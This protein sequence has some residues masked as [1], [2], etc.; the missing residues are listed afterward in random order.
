MFVVL[1]WQ[2]LLFSRW[3]SNVFLNHDTIN[4]D[5]ERHRREIKMVHCTYNC[6]FSM[7]LRALETVAEVA[8]NASSTSGGSGSSSRSRSEN[9]TSSSSSN[10]DNPGNIGTWFETYIYIYIS[11]IMPA[12]YLIYSIC[13]SGTIQVNAVY[14][15]NEASPRWVYTMDCCTIYC[16]WRFG[17][18]VVLFGSGAIN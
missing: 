8:D 9:K 16:R 14:T 1:H 2:D 18:V 11:L 12:I 17:K 15:R 4:A 7:E 5:S 10:Y 6:L 13:T 3:N